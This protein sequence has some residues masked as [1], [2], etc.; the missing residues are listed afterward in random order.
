MEAIIALLSVL[1][2]WN[3]ILTVALLNVKESKDDLQQKLNRFPAQYQ[4]KA[5]QEQVDRADTRRREFQ[6]SYLEDFQV[7]KDILRKLSTHLGLDIW[8]RHQPEAKVVEISE[9][10]KDEEESDEE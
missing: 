4:V 3:I 10:P 1:G 6:E 7:I 9:L 8:V 2:V 5:I